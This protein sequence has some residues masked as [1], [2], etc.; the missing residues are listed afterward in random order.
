MTDSS[1]S[2]RGEV[3]ISSQIH[4][5]GPFTKLQSLPHNRSMPIRAGALAP[6]LVIILTTAARAQDVQ[7]PAPTLTDAYRLFY[8]ARYEEAAA[9][10]MALRAAGGQDLENDE[11]RT[12]A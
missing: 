2:V 3:H 6:M 10:A 8:N 1:F 9:L 11:V 7:V 12:S 5:C 4:A